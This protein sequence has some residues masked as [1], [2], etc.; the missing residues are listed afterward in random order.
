MLVDLHCHTS[1]RSPCSVLQPEE[2]VDLAH[3]RGLDGICLTEHDRWWS[4]DELDALRRRTGFP[5]FA[6]VELT[7]DRGHILAY[8]LGEPPAPLTT[9]E[10]VAAEARR[11]R[12]VLYLAHPARDGLLRVDRQLVD[13]VA[14]VEAF[15]GSDTRLQNVA[16]TGLAHGFPLPGIG[17]GDAHT[18]DELGRAAT[19]FDMRIATSV[20]L[21]AALLAGRYSAT[22][23]A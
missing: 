16:A 13:A 19:R 17:G 23:L 11:Q 15:N 18:A 1:L 12:A 5:I 21:I 20:D 3:A 14:S 2:L 9:L 4:E 10:A 22:F 8:G 7:T 6:G